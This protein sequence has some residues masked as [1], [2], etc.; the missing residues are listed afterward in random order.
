MEGKIGGDS[1]LSE[2]GWQYAKAL[3]QLV[4][5]AVGDAPL[6]VWHSTLKRTAQTA[7]FLPYPKLAWKSLDELDAGVC[8]S[9]TYEEIE[10]YYPEDYASRDDD[11]FN[12]R[13]RGGESYRDVVVRLE[14]IIMELERQENILII[15]HQAILR[16]LYAYFHSLNQEELPYIKIPLHTLLELVSLLPTN[17]VDLTRPQTPAAFG[18][19]ERRF[20]APIEA[21]NTHRDKPSREGATS[22]LSASTSPPVDPLVE[23]STMPPPSQTNPDRDVKND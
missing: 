5:D 1:N 20:K 21:V 19:R 16:A 3:P 15:G 4:K 7:S 2:R 9:M 14:P 17:K 18:T 10:Q 23:A 11:K 6:T 8:D 13:Y 22:L 12:Y